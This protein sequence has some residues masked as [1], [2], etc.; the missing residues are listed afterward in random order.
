MFA[1]LVGMRRLASAA[2]IFDRTT[3]LAS[4]QFDTDH[5]VFRQETI[6]TTVTFLFVLFALEQ[7][8]E[9]LSTETI[10]ASP[11]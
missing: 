8:Y 11:S 9:T 6:G 7:V 1:M 5:V 4:K 10:N 2:A 3:L